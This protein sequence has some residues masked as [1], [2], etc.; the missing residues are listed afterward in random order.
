MKN[1]LFFSMMS[2]NL[3]NVLWKNWQ[4]FFRITLIQKLFIVPI[5]G[6]LNN[7]AKHK[8]TI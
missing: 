1:F 3:L 5:L 8:K 7:S 6:S 2:H 4:D